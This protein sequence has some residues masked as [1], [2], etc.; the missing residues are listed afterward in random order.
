MKKV[1]I[2]C[3]LVAIAFSGNSEAFAAKKKRESKKSKTAVEQPAVKK[4]PAKPVSKYDALFKG[5]KGYEVA[6]GNFLTLHKVDGKLYVEFPLK[7]MGREVLIATVGS[8]NSNSMFCTNGYKENAPMHVRFNIEDSTVY[9]YKP[10]ASAEFDLESER[11]KIILKR[12]YRE[13]ILETYKIL[14][15]N[16]DKSAVVIDMTQMFTGSDPLLSPVA[17]T[18]GPFQISG[19]PKPGT[20]KLNE[21]KAF[22]DNVTVKT[23]YSYLISMRAGMS[24]VMSNEPA[25]ILATRSLILL[26][27][28]GMRTRITDA[29]IGTFLTSKTLLSENEDQIKT[30]T[31]ANRWRIEPKDIEA[32]KRGELV[33]PTKPIVFYLDDAFPEL[34]KESIKEGVSW[35][36]ASFEKIGFKNAVQVR[37]FPKDDPSFDPDNIKYS[38]I[39]YI[40]SNVANA[41]GPSWADPR[42]GEIINASVV[43]HNDITKLLNSW[44]FIQTAQIDP[45]VRAQKMPDD[46]IKESI[47]CVAAHEVGH[48]LGLMHNMAATNAYPVDSLRS[49]TFT[50]KY[51]IT[52]SIMDYA[53]Y[54]YIAQPEDKGVSL[55]PPNIGV[56]DDFAIKYLYSYL[57]DAKDANSETSIVES[58]VDEKAGD[59]MFRFGKQQFDARFDP[60]AMEEDLGNDA[61]KAGDYAIKNLKYITKN[62][63]MWITDDPDY[64]HLHMLMTG[65]G[66]QFKRNVANVICNIGGV[67]LTEVKQGTNGAKFEATPRQLQRNSVKWVVNQ[68]KSCDWLNNPNLVSGFDLELNPSVR[69]RAALTKQ[70]FDSRARVALSAHV[71]KEPYK[72]SEFFDDVYAEIWANAIQNRKM[73]EGERLMQ[74]AFINL[75]TTGNGS[76]A[77]PQTGMK[78]MNFLPS[79]D[80]VCLY[81]LDETGLVNQYEDMLRTLEEQEGKGYVAKLIGLNKFGEGFDWQKDVDTQLVDDSSIQIYSISMKLKSL[82]ASA[83]V[84]NADPETRKFYKLCLYK[85]ERAID[86][87]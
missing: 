14:A 34:W 73:S 63:D 26:P 36:N 25:T 49:A 80:E 31:V 5:K 70:L 57:P 55:T 23:W 48:C 69:I 1:L 83:S 81:G 61:L 56:Y 75:I 79:L 8:D 35:W 40:P 51:G 47:A 45:R 16:N 68:I 71:S 13:P 33:E 24:N 3:L 62:M 28:V 59:P 10:N 67:N 74:T 42:T 43:I 87:K 29:R 38:C 65:I 12:N 4:E 11:K 64:K 52:P 76:A 44:R 41:M 30:Y 86:K 58:W 22:D 82:L 39:R 20:V 60:T 9:M 17:K 32:Y 50:K 27:E 15:Y 21:I 72:M 78:S 2:S 54:N 84:N 37:D 77:T 19:S 18:K 66:D 6:K 85:L 53:R 7:H 46:I